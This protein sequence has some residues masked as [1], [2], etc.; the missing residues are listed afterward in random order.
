MPIAIAIAIASAIVI[1]ACD[2]SK[3]LREWT[4]DDHGQP[5]RPD[6]ERVPSATESEPESIDPALRAA[7][8]LFNAAC[9]TCHG[10]EGGGGGPN[11]PP[12]VAVPNFGDRAWQSARSDEELAKVIREGRNTM[13]AFGEQLRAEGVDA[14]VAYVRSL[15]AA[16]QPTPAA[17]D[18]EG[19]DDPGAIEAEQER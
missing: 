2:S 3:P 11:L 9:A 8:A 10:R 13:P 19:G 7:R 12:G 17:A 18:S 14:L 5:Q 1:A 6:M 15:G 16:A 4:P